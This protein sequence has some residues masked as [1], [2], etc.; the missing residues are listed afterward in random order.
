[1]SQILVRKKREQDGDIFYQCYNNTMLRWSHCY[2]SWPE[3][4][5]F[6][7][8]IST[9]GREFCLVLRKKNPINVNMSKS[10]IFVSFQ[11]AGD[12]RRKKCPKVWIDISFL[13]KKPFM[14]T[15]VNKPCW[16]VIL[17]HSGFHY[18]SAFTPYWNLRYKNYSGTC[19]LLSN[20][21][22]AVFV[23]HFSPVFDITSM[24]WHKDLI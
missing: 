18:Y 1:M 19:C 23:V 10:D 5:L 22:G 4:F 24:P 3:R 9:F 17:P 6:R 7:N 20:N 21:Y 2:E 13:E 8:E 11:P 16:H 12:L 15:L 14:Q